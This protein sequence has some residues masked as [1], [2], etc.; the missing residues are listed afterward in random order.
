MMN[1]NCRSCDMDTSGR[2]TCFKGGLQQNPQEWTKQRY[3]QSKEWV[4]SEEFAPK[5][6]YSKYFLEKKSNN[7]RRLFGK[8]WDN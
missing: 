5:E 7:L 1:P 2:V 6:S 8:G 3:T 4:A